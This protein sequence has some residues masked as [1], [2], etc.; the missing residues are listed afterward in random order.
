MAR[1]RSRRTQQKSASQTAASLL[2]LALPAPV[3]R[4]ADTQL[5]SLFLLVVIPAAIVLGL[6]NIDW[7]GG[8][9]SVSIDQQRA[10]E[11]GNV[12]RDKYNNFESQ[13]GLQNLGQSATDLL[14]QAQNY[15]SQNYSLPG[16]S[17]SSSTHPA[18]YSQPNTNNQSQP[19]AANR[20]FSAFPSS[21]PDQQRPQQQV[22]PNTQQ[23]AQQQQNSQQPSQQ[24]WRSYTPSTVTQNTSNYNTASTNSGYA[25]KPADPGSSPS[26]T[27]SL[28]YQQQEQLRQQQVYQQQLY[29]QQL[30]DQQLKQYQYQQWLA[31]QN[32]APR[33]YTQQSGLQNQNVQTNT[34]PY[35][36]QPP[37]GYA[38]PQ[39]DAYGRP[40]TTG[41]PPP[42]SQQTPYGQPSMQPNTQPNYNQGS[43]PV[44]NTGGRY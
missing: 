36:N 12:A 44:V 18:G 5:G 20:N 2:A 16:Y 3:Q 11:I 31:Q 4:I 30:Y 24:D 42:T 26:D 1:S 27:R 37:A 33:N 7:N 43:L 25:T 29:Q 35:A 17:N 34:Q 14:S 28:T 19:T 40:V 9:P 6:I 38:Y 22:Q 8:K 13:G 39:T 23:Y 15:T 21:Q 41:F 32:S 10:A